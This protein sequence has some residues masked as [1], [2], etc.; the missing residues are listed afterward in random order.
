MVKALIIIISSVLG[1]SIIMLIS[2][3]LDLT[4]IIFSLDKIYSKFMDLEKNSV[5]S[6]NAFFASLISE[7]RK[8]FKAQGALLFLNQQNHAQ[9]G[10]CSFDEKKIKDMKCYLNIKNIELTDEDIEKIRRGKLSRQMEKKLFSTEYVNIS[11][12]YKFSSVFPIFKK[13]EVNSFVVLLYSNIFRFFSGRRIMILNMNRLTQSILDMIIFI[14]TRGENQYSVMM[15]NIR[16]YA[17]ISCD[18][19]MN[20]KTWNKGA[21]IMFGFE[22]DDVIE[23]DFRNYIHPEDKEAFQY[24]Y[25]K[26]LMKDEIKTKAKMF[27]S[28]STVLIC[29]ILIKQIKLQNM[30][31][32]FYILI[33]DVSKDEVIKNNMRN[34]AMINRSIV[35][36]SR[37]GII[38]LNQN[39]KIVFYNEKLKKIS[40]SN[41][42]FL[43]MDIST[44]FHRTLGEE[45]KQRIEEIKES[46]LEFNTLDMRTGDFWYN[47]RFFPITGDEDHHEGVIMFFVDN[48]LWM[49]H[50]EEMLVKNQ[51]LE[52]MNRRLLNDLSAAHMMQHNLVP[53]SLPSNSEVSYEEIFLLSEEVGGDFYF[54]E[55]IELNKNKY[56]LNMMTDV[57]GHGVA[58]S[59]FSV[60]V[61][62][63]FI[64][65]KE[66]IRSTEQLEPAI[67]IN[68]LNKKLFE[69]RLESH[70]FITAYFMIMDVTKKT[71]YFS[72]AGHPQMVLI[73]NNKPLRF[74]GINN[75]PPLGI[76]ETF[77]YRSDRV[78]I[79]SDDKFIIYTDGLLDAFHSENSYY[80]VFH[81]FIIEHREETLSVM[82]E[83]IEKRIRESIKDSDINPDD[84]TVLLI[85]FKK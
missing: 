50:R 64:D 4:T 51:L 18:N 67:L 43:G 55:E 26:A 25:E 21:E 7:M 69:L 58:S 65:Y 66:S 29:E 19:K 83:N 37:D 28:N 54:V 63:I 34:R 3:F 9:I 38:V 40:D 59:M 68:M 30:N 62:E 45:I 24:I 47:I 52:E 76:A 71:I 72:S 23:R 11:S 20:I 53:E 46:N 73:R 17:F 36:N 57:S 1:I 16:D 10:F 80:E 6:S 49:K 41:I 79:K 81:S 22:T 82:K 60:F 13:N 78:E 32:G 44:I 2:F 39:D 61:K 33:K 75:S 31:M 70:R 48:S 85:Q 8:L 84:I 77:N 27:D 56:Y 74:F 5:D 15:E 12:L 14:Q 35:E 42:T